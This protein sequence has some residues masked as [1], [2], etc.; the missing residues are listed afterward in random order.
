MLDGGKTPL[1]VVHTTARR[2]F[3]GGQNGRPT[4]IASRGVRTSSH[5]W[6]LFLG[7]RFCPNIFLVSETK[8]TNLVS[9]VE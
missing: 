5:N 8:Y 4:M 2:S 7:V 1:K 3:I 6:L 9:R